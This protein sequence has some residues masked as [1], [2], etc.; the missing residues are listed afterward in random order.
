MHCYALDGGCERLVLHDGNSKPIIMKWNNT[1]DFV[2][3]NI[4]IGPILVTNYS[5]SLSP[6]RIGPM[7]LTEGKIREIIKSKGKGFVF[8]TKYF[9]SKVDDVSIVTSALS[10]LV[11]KKIIRRLAHGLYDLPEVHPK[12]G[13]VMPTAAKVIDAIVK[14]EAL[15]VQ[16]TGAYAANLLGL[17]TQIPMRI[18]LYTNGPKKC[19]RYGKQE[20]LLRPTTPKNM[21]GAGTKAG[22]I[23]HALRQIGKDNVSD[24]M[25]GHIKSQL[26]EADR[27]Q[28]KKQAEY[29]PA[30][31][32]KIMRELIKEI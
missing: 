15:Q 8:T 25:I 1:N 19:I 7:V 18:E 6:K 17:S 22:L 12:L 26:E 27:K 32:A 3:N 29:A 31:I 13:Q 10:R 14:S 11:Q 2:Q 28:L 9:S 5:I 20:I 24:K 4:D 30:W 23:L 16:P 21:I